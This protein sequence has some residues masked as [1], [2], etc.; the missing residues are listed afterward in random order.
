MKKSKIKNN[1][2]VLIL[3]R[4][5]GLVT[6]NFLKLWSTDDKYTRV[7]ELTKSLLRYFFL[8]NVYDQ[9]KKTLTT[10]TVFVNG[11]RTLNAL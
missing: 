4:G 11:S 9:K 3:T 6:F 7:S 10:N 5:G 8:I 2:S 1:N